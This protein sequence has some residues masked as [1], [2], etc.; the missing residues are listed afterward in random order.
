[1][2]SAENYNSELNGLTRWAIRLGVQRAAAT[3]RFWKNPEDRADLDAAD[4][5]ILRMNE[6]AEALGQKIGVSLSRMLQ[7]AFDIG[8]Q[9]S[10]YGLRTHQVIALAERRSQ[11]FG[12]TY[13]LH[14]D[15]KDV[16]RSLLDVK[17]I[18]FEVLEIYSS[19]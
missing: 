15:F 12:H 3:E 19:D 14:S 5:G 2:N 9:Y 17:S 7:E 18:V 6:R 16:W 4:D 8:R 11:V 1:M 13:D 10:E